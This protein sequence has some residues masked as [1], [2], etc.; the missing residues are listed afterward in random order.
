M[1]AG[2]NGDHGLAAALLAEEGTPT[3]TDLAPT[4]HLPKEEMTATDQ[5]W[6]RNAATLM[7]APNAKLHWSSV[8]QFAQEVAE[9]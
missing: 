8:L 1:V 3:D 9:I 7:T 4:H 2:H 6:N 5:T